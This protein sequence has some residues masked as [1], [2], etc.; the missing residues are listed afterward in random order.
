MFVRNAMVNSENLITVQVTDSLAVA[1]DKIE[2]NNFLSLPVLDGSK[3]Y[4][5]IFK[6]RIY[7]EFFN[8]EGVTKEDYLSNRQVKEM[9]SVDIPFVYQ[10]QLIE[11]VAHMLREYRIPFVPVLNNDEEKKFVGIITHYVIFDN[12]MNIFGTKKGYR[13][14]YKG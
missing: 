10:D 14:N 1:L 8:C 12:F 5:V 9:A 6:E 7:R 4:G 2:S 13:Y 11:E 3:F